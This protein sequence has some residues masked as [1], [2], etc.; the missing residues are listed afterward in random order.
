MREISEY[1]AE[2]MRRADEKKRARKRR[3]TAAVSAGVPLALA[4]VVVLPRALKGVGADAAPQ[5]PAEAELLPA[6]EHELNAEAELLPADEQ[7]QNAEVTVFPADVPEGVDGFLLSPLRFEV[8][9]DGETIVCGDPERAAALMTLIGGLAPDPE[10]AEHSGGS[11]TRIA[12]YYAEG[13]PDLFSLVGS[14][15]Y[16]DNGDQSFTLD[17]AA[18][19]ELYALLDIKQ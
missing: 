6:D 10:P 14:V 15:L 7:E 12:L 4:L 2:V 11:E 9:T 17:E 19:S 16:D 1:T 5:A 8:I 18:L 13:G 3:I